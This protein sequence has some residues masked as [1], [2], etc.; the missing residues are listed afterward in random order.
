M[1]LLGIDIGRKRTGVAYADTSAGFVMALDT[2]KHTTTEEIVDRLV[3]MATKKKAG[4]IIVGLP[5]LPQGKEGSQAQHVRAVADLLQKR[6]SI[7][8]TFMDERYTS[9]GATW[10]CDTDAKAACD[11]L[12]VALDQRKTSY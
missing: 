12:S 11:L 8:V 9:L 3:V 4:E 7:P 1:I 10:D 6:L 5:K 2:V